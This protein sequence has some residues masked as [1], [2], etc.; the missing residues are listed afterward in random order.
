M[1]GAAGEKAGWQSFRDILFDFDKSDIRASETEKIKAV[2][3]FAQQNAGFQIGLDGYAD[4]R[5]GDSYNQRLSNRRVKAVSAALTA[6][7]VSANRIRTGA[8]GEKNRNCTESTEECYQRNRRVE[9]FV[10]PGG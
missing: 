8:F 2:A 9:V 6:A 1:A 10:R 7:G 5:G 3:D 4:P